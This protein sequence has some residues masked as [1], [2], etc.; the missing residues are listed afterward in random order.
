MAESGRAKTWVHGRLGKLIELGAATQIR[1]GLYRPMPDADLRR[2]MA[3]I[4]AEAARLFGEA[5]ESVHAG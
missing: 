1:R 5:R 4:D 3:T 2:A